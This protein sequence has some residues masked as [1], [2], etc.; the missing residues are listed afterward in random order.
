MAHLAPSL[1]NVVAQSAGW[2]QVTPASMG[3]VAS[4]AAD[5]W[6]LEVSTGPKFHNIWRILRHCANRAY[7]HIFGEESSKTLS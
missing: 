3:R 4:A 7:K 2:C 5:R 1:P 6:P